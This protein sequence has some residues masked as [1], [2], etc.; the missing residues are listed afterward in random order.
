LSLFHADYFFAQPFDN[1]L[2]KTRI[3]KKNYHVLSQKTGKA[4]YL[5]RL[6][7]AAILAGI[8]LF[9]EIA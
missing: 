3:A 5:L 8:P 9:T 7:F 2:F 6:S 4:P 1:P